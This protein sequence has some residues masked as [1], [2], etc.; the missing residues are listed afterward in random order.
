VSEGR[1]F[2]IDD[3]IADQPGL[4]FDDGANT[5]ATGHIE[6]GDMA[7]SSGGCT[8]QLLSMTENTATLI[9]SSS[10]PGMYLF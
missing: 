8:S 7:T 9:D 10:K 4:T 2:L 5:T 1:D 6:S 3:E